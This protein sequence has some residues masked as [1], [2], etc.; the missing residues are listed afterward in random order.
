MPFVGVMSHHHKYSKINRN[1]VYT[2]KKEEEFCVVVNQRIHDLF[3]YLSF[4]F[5]RV[6]VHCVTK[7]VMHLVGFDAI[8]RPL[9]ERSL[10]SKCLIQPICV[11]LFA[12]AASEFMRD[13]FPF[14][15]LSD[16]N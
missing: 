5:P 2:R 14:I 7:S 6:Y 15:Y 11:F 8:S 3:C 9:N 16:S 10:F 4:F 12:R 13:T 1:S